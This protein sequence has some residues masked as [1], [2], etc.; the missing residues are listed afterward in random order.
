MRHAALPC[1]LAAVAACAESPAPRNALS[2]RIDS[3]GIT[4][5][6]NH[7]TL[8]GETPQWEVAASPFLVI[9]HDER[10]PDSSPIDPATPY[11]QSNGNIVVADGLSA[12]THRLLIY[13]STGRFLFSAG[14]EGKG[15]CEF[16]QL[17]WVSGL[18]D[19]SMAAYD[20]AEHRV[21]IFDRA[22][23]C[24][25]MIPLPRL[26]A[27]EPAGTYGFSAGADG[28]FRDGSILAHA[29]GI[30]DIA[31][32]G[33]APWYVHQ[34]L[35]VRPDGLAWDTVGTFRIT[36][37]NWDGTRQ[38]ARHFT[39]FAHRATDAAEIVYTSGE[40]PEFVRLTRSGRL[41]QV[42]RIDRPKQPLTAAMRNAYI[43]AV[44]ER[45]RL[46]G[47]EGGPE[48]A[49]RARARF[50]MAVWPSALPDVGSLLVDSL[51][52]VWLARYVNRTLGD[53]LGYGDRGLWD[54]VDR[55]GKWLGTITLPGAFKPEAIYPEAMLGLWT[56]NDGTREVRGYGLTR[57]VG[58]Q[59]PSN[60]H[61]SCCAQWSHS[62]RCRRVHR[63]VIRHVSRCLL[64]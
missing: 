3:A 6:T 33:E 35:S 41:T 42:V 63:T 26:P 31:R 27:K 17:W 7:E 49:A 25:R 51:G 52:Y 28:V 45:T 62:G 59:T 20:Y 29:A 4:I 64:S 38:T 34:L 2:S 30:V 23:K 24:A 22:G 46:A 57:N 58:K 60:P 12:G 43:E 18:P 37:V 54:I 19:D 44:V 50:E 55:D 13:D 36:Q 10:N 53:Q 39:P 16:S 40:N 47:F 9:A 8:W 21:S 48:A 1:I 15:P 11:R 5:I 56:N 61:C 32:G 14:R